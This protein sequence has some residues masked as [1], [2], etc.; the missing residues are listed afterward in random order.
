MQQEVRFLFAASAFFQLL[1]MLAV[2]AGVS[3]SK[4]FILISFPML[5]GWAAFAWAIFKTALLV[6]AAG[7]LRRRRWSHVRLSDSEHAHCNTHGSPSLFLHARK[8]PPNT[9]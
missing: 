2:S 1:L 4:V 6:E 7:A 9:Y 5:S 8:C 3:A